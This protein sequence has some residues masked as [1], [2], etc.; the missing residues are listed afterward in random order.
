MRSGARRKVAGL[1]TSCSSA[2]QAR[3]ER[4]SG[5]QARQQQQGVHEDVA[6]G[7]KLRGLLDALHARD[8][9]Q[10][11]AQQAAFV[12]QQEGA[13][14][15][16]FGQH[17]GQ[18]VANPLAGDLVD[19]RREAADGFH[20][21]GVDGVSEARG[22]AHG[23]QHAQLVLGEALLRR[24]DGAHQA[25]LQVAPAF[26]VV[27]QLAV[28]S[29]GMRGERIEQQ[30]VDG[31]V[32]PL[33]VMLRR[34]GVAHRVG[35]AAVEIG[36]V[37]AEGGDLDVALIARISQR[38]QRHQHHSELRADGVGLGKDAH[39]LVGRGRGG[40]V[41][42][43]GLA[44]QQQIAHASAHPQSLVAV[45]AEKPDGCERGFALGKG[46]GHIASHH[47]TL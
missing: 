17:L 35:M 33:H 12:Q 40:N 26:D 37:G 32:A 44:A 41:V 9:R 43:G 30:A 34:G 13:A 45:A 3:V 23:A 38:F 42:I 21:R 4:A 6:L 10:Q 24:A 11:F 36:S 31:E 5:G 39:D 47:R 22:K 7:M 18:L 2:P 15:L 46:T 8:L 1:P 29:V 14:R 28:R 20:G 16:S 19:L 25:A 27:E